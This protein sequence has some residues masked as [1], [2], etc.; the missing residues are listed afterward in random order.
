MRNNQVFKLPEKGMKE[1]T[2]MKRMEAGS[3]HSKE[4]YTNGGKMSGGVY[5]S[6]D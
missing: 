5:M 4:Y 2:I 3:S 6:D 1:D